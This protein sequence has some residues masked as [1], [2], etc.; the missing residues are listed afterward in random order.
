MRVSRSAGQ[1]TTRYDAGQEQVDQHTD[2]RVWLAFSLLPVLIVV[3]LL[4]LY[5]RSL[6]IPR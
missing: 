3:V 2:R 4:L 1:S 5:I 6:P